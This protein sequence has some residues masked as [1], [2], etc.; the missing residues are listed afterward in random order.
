[1]TGE[2]TDRAIRRLLV[3][4]YHFPP[5]GSVGGFRWA[6]LSKYLAREG[7]E[8]HVVT[9]SAQ[10]A[11]ALEPGVTVHYRPQRKTLNDLYNRV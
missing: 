6:G 5:D 3:I 7:W 9:A 1:M 10:P 2:S 11:L 8:V 4:S